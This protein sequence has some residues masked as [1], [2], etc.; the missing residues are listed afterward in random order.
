MS[1]VYL[2]SL[3][4]THWGTIRVILGLYGV[5]GAEKGSCYIIAG[6]GFGIMGIYSVG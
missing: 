5:N 2:E 1:R 4:G 6:L 3:G